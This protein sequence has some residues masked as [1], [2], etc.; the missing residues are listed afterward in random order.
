MNGVMIVFTFIVII[1][2]LNIKFSDKAKI[3]DRDYKIFITNIESVA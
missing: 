2:I 1:I 3:A